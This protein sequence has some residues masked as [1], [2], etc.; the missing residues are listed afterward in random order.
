MSGFILEVWSFFIAFKYFIQESLSD[1]ASLN[2]SLLLKCFLNVSNFES[3]L[4]IKDDP[5]QDSF[6]FNLQIE[7]RIKDAQ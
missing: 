3:S 4:I 7:K 6:Y 2:N 1:I 5:Q